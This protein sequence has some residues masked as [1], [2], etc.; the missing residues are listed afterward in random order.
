MQGRSLVTEGPP[1]PGIDA[2]VTTRQ[3]DKVFHRPRGDVSKQAK[4]DTAH[5]AVVNLNGEIDAVGNFGEGS[6]DTRITRKSVKKD[7]N[8]KEVMREKKYGVKEEAYVRV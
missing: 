8:D 7:K 1:G 2:P 3:G 5:L 4:D 6:E